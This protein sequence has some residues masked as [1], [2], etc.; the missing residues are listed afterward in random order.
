MRERS[1]HIQASIEIPHTCCCP[2][3]LD[4]ETPRDWGM[5]GSWMREER[6]IAPGELPTRGS[7][8]ET[9]RPQRLSMVQSGEVEERQ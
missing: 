7:T 4:D 5:E 8:R 9:G 3:R 2:S 6:A 1:A